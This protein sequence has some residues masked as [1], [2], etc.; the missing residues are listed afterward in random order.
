LLI[1]PSTLPP[2]AVAEAF[3]LNVAPGTLARQPFPCSF[4]CPTLRT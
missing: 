3:G 1:A 4:G 2:H